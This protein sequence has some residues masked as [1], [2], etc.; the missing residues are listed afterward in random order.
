MRKLGVLTISGKKEQEK[1][2]ETEKYHRTERYFGSFSR[3]ISVPESITEKD[4]KA[5]I[6][7]GVLEVTFPNKAAKKEEAKKITVN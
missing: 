7:N 4:I 3:S 1:K 5:K 2:E 6:D